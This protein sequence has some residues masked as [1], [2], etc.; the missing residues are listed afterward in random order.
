MLAIGLPSDEATQ[1][2]LHGA[3]MEVRERPCGMPAVRLAGL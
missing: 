3:R 2:R 1:G